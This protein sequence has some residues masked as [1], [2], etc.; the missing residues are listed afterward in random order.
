MTVIAILV[1]AVAGFGAGYFLA[2]VWAQ[3]DAYARAAA[4]FH[5]DLNQMLNWQIVLTVAAERE[6]LDTEPAHG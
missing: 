6:F 2:W 4:S 1:I 5:R 3:A